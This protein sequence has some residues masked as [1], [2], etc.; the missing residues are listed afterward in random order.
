MST[1]IWW[2]HL[3]WIVAAGVIG[4]AVAALFAGQLQLSR[5]W[6]LIPHLLFS[7]GLVAGY[8]WWSDIDLI[9]LFH[10][11][12]LWGIVAAALAGAFLVANVLSQPASARSNGVMALIDLAWLGVVYGLVDALLLSVLPIVAT[13]HAFAALGWTANW[14]GRI[15]AGALALALS[16]AVTAAYHLGF[17]EFQGAQVAGPLIGNG[18]SSLA[19]VVTANPLGALLSHLAMHVAAVLQGPGTTIQLPPHY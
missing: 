10:R 18:V 19:Y 5:R 4:F 12:W 17:P 3:L 2:Q 6:F 14:P 1:T 11:H 13:W 8:F 9:A 7:G 16:L 15:G